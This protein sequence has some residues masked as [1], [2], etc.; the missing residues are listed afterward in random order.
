M[1]RPQNNAA[2]CHTAPCFHTHTHTLTRCQSDQA[3]CRRAQRGR[4]CRDLPAMTT[5]GE[6]CTAADVVYSAERSKKTAKEINKNL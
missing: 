5:G 4:L 1:L 6:K 2:V 3:E